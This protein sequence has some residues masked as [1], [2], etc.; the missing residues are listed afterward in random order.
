M[1]SKKSV[2]TVPDGNGWKNVQAGRDISHHRTKENAMERGRTEARHDQT[3]HVE[4]NRNGR[5]SG[6]N[7]YGN[8]PC[9]PK[10]KR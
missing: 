6:S 5:I 3:E 4:H 2:H 9:P 10:D 7:S 1:A 8:D